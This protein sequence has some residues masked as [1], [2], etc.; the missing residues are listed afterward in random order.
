MACC[1]RR[2]IEAVGLDDPPLG[3]ARAVALAVRAVLHGDQ[4]GLDQAAVETLR[5]GFGQAERLLL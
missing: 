5:L 1:N 4:A 3:V 2:Q